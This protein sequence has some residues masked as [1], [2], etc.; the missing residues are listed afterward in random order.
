VSRGLV[1]NPSCLFESFLE[2]SA[3]LD[4]LGPQGSHGRILFEAVPMRYDDPGFDTV[5]RRAQSYGLS[6]IPTR[7]GNDRSDGTIFC[8][9]RKVDQ[10]SSDL[11]RSDRSVILVLDP[12]IDSEPITEQG[13]TIL[14]R[15]RKN[16]VDDL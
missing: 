11:E 14:G 9:V 16:R 1:R 2:V 8:K 7:G 3:M 6:M 12:D 13:P 4:Q 10:A 15:W 5:T